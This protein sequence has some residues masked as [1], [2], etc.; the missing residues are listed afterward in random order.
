[1]TISIFLGRHLSGTAR[2]KA[3]IFI[4]LNVWVNTRIRFQLIFLFLIS[5][6]I[7]AD[8][9][10]Y[11]G[12]TSN[13][14]AVFFVRPLTVD[15]RDLTALFMCEFGLDLVVCWLLFIVF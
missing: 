11:R 3:F 5:S 8:S 12:S 13:T 7:R 4:L 14:S 1:M 6:E 15:H 10:T 2:L 9:N